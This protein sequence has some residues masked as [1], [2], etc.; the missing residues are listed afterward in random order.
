MAENTTHEV[1]PEIS[2]SAVGTPANGAAQPPKADPL[3]RAAGVVS[4]VNAS[5]DKVEESLPLDKIQTAGEHMPG[6]MGM[7][8]KV[9]DSVNSEEAAQQVA[10][11]T[12]ANPTL[13]KKQIADL[14][15][16]DKAKKTAVV[17]GAT[18]ATAV[19]PGVGSIAALTLGMGV[20]IV[21]TFRYQ[22]ELIHEIALVFGRE[23]TR[24]ER[25]NAVVG[26]MGI[27]VGL[28]MAVEAMT[29]R[30]ATRVGREMT[31][32]AILKVVPVAGLVLGAGL[33]VASTYIIGKR[34]MTYFG[35]EELKSIEAEMRALNPDDVSAMERLRVQAES[36]GA[37]MAPKL[38]AAKTWTAERAADWG[39]KV[40]AAAVVAGQRVA[41]AAAS[42]AKT[43]GKKVGPAAAGAARGVQGT[44][45]RIRPRKQD[46]ETPID[47]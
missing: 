33:D 46:D 4:G 39:P 37:A 42:A 41:P 43:A 26:I 8:F 2:E 24:T 27:G 22:A 18:A 19:V 47:S 14:L 5:L 28:D 6:I 29:A 9:V 44:F 40:G 7:I 35:G 11:V 23:L 12:A 10:R 38:D 34:A 31:E 32:R 20:D 45:S 30:V 16:R 13:N 15:I 36:V 25:R 21:L 3:A 1:A 17:G